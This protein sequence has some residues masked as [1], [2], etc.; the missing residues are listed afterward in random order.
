[1]VYIV[2][3]IMI[4]G[5]IT[6]VVLTVL[7]I[8]WVKHPEKYADAVK[9]HDAETREKTAYRAKK[10]Q[11]RQAALKKAKAKE[12]QIKHDQ[13]MAVVN[14]YRMKNSGKTLVGNDLKKEGVKIPDQKK[15]K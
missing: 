9:E 8:D 7:R 1:M 11:D 14:K 5:A 2:Y 3:G 13:R 4:V 10:E 12:K 15:K 6:L